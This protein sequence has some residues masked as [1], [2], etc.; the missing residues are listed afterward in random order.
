MVQLFTTSVLIDDIVLPDGQTRM[1][2]L[3]GGGPQSAFGMKLWASGGVGL[4]GS[5]GPDFPPAAQTWLD[6]LG[7]D[8]TGVRRDPQH[9]T[10]RAWQVLEEDGRRTQVWRT[11]PESIPPHM[12]LRPE[13]VPPTWWGARGFHFGVHPERPNLVLAATLRA[14]GV[15][16]SV[17]PFRPAAQ[18]LHDEDL[19][20]LVSAGD[21]FSPNLEEARSLV[22]DGDPQTLVARLAAA[23]AQIVT[24]RMGGEGSLIYNRAEGSGPHFVPPVPAAVVD[25][26]GAGN[27]Y[28]GGFL[29]GWLEWGDLRQAGR[30]AAVAGSFLVEQ[31]GLPLARPGLQAEAHARLARLG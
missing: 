27:A 24:L 31:Y 7:I 13:Q 29:A 21:I 28:C 15:T 9:P 26:V 20:A 4:C 18:P 25:P 22:G 5:V 19:A 17:E 2:L 14:R 12:G 23:G 11:R 6:A 10:L 3:G 1:G 16:V 8:T 30:C